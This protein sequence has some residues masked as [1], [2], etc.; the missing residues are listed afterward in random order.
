MA[1][2]MS[3]RH[4]YSPGHGLTADGLN[5]TT[6]FVF[7]VVREDVELSSVIRLH[8][9]TITHHIQHIALHIVV[10]ILQ[11][12]VELSSVVLARVTVVV[13]WYDANSSKLPAA[14]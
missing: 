4:G 13:E 12:L 8:K 5:A 9:H 1:M 14:E 10:Q 11:E 3:H 2:G 6:A 7:C